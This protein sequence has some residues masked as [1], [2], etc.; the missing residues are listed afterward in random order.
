MAGTTNRISF[1]E[2]ADL[3]TSARACVS[4][5]VDGVPHVEPAVVRRHGERFVIG[6]D[7]ALPGSDGDE[8]VLLI[9]EGILFFDL[10][11]IHVRGVA[12]PTDDERGDGRCWY[13]IEPSKVTCWDYGRLRA[14]D[15]AE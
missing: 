12:T 6:I 2:A 8:A 14:G 7:A 1:D 11:A 3:V 15:G 10:R 5:V 4:Y 13:E 9:D